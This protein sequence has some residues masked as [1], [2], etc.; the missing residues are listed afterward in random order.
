M[1]DKSKTK[2]LTPL[3]TK[4]AL[5]Q[6]LGHII[7]T[8]EQDLYNKTRDQLEQYWHWSWDNSNSIEWNVYSFFRSLQIYECFC[9]RWEGKHEGHCCVVERVRDRYLLPKISEFLII[10]QEVLHA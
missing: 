10:L 4:D 7:N 5:D 3:L 2:E 1:A 8:F 6:V 9:R